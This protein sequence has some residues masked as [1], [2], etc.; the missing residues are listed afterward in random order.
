MQLD[1]GRIEGGFAEKYAD[2]F[3]LFD[4]TLFKTE[5]SFDDYFTALFADIDVRTQERMIEKLK[6]VHL[7]FYGEIKKDYSLMCFELM[8]LVFSERLSANKKMPIIFDRNGF[9]MNSGSLPQFSS[10]IQSTWS[11]IRIRQGDYWGTDKK[12]YVFH[13]PIDIPQLLIWYLWQM[14]PS[15]SILYQLENDLPNFSAYEQNINEFKQFDNLLKL[16]K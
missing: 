14:Y 6:T 11:N 1:I 13:S 9:H 10:Y 16:I 5:F 2:Y 3:A 12:A 7:M 4:K 8:W 15:P